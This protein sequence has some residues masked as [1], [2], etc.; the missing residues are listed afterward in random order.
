MTADIERLLDETGWQLLQALQ[1]NARLSFQALGQRVGLSAPAV[2]ERI[3]RMEDAGII[4]GYRAEIDT[5]LIG[6]PITAIV[7]ISTPMGERYSQFATTAPEIAE[8]LEC[9][10][11]TGNDALVMKVAVSSV[12][13]LES[14]I[15]R[16]SVYGQVTTSIVLSA[17]VTH[18][19]ITRQT[20]QPPEDER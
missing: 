19:T 10:H 2:A 14:L 6:L 7:R 9:Y 3:R 5:A 12:K 20:L 1:E 11:V 17:P 18:R 16:L 8:V 15:D 13:H 4:K